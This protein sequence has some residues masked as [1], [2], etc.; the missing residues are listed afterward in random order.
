MRGVKRLCVGP[1]EPADK[2]S[3][4]LSQP[5]RPFLETKWESEVSRKRREYRA[6]D[7]FNVMLWRNR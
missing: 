1:G 2:T 3:V 5:G 7:V 6:P 4:E